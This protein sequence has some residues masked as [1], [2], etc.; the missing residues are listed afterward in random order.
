MFQTLIFY[1]FGNKFCF[2]TLRITLQVTTKSLKVIESDFYHSHLV[3]YL[4]V[5]LTGLHDSKL[6][7]TDTWLHMCPGYPLPGL[8]SIVL[9]HRMGHS[10]S[11]TFVG[12]VSAFLGASQTDAR[13]VFFESL[14]MMH[15]MIDEC[16]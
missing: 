12:L 2:D 4:I 7:R 14:E 8:M 9:P 6:R 10:L 13:T 11:L 3:S 15:R 1:N 5:L 16:T